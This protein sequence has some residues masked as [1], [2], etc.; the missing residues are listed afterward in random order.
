MDYPL[1][2]NETARLK[3]LERYVILDTLGSTVFLGVPIA[4][5]LV[6]SSLDALRR[7]AVLR[8]GDAL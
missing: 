8:Y 7:E 4:T 5:G 3:A 6:S 2:P 1:P